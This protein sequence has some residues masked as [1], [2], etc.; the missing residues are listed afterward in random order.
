MKPKKKSIITR[1]S[2]KKKTQLAFEDLILDALAQFKTEGY[3]EQL[4]T[5]FTPESWPGHFFKKHHLLPF[6]YNQIAQCT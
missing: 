3:M 1:L 6:L 2:L 5:N 4:K